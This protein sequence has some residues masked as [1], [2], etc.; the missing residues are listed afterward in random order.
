MSG[1]RRS[2]ALLGLA[3]DLGVANRVEMPGWLEREALH[4]QKEGH[5]RVNGP[6][7]LTQ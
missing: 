1:E 5:T 3:R 7:A 6:L 2:A 4:P